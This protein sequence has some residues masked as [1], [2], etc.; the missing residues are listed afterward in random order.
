MRIENTNQPKKTTSTKKNKQATGS[1]FDGL[2]GQV[3][4]TNNAAA[5]SGASEVSAIDGLLSIQE[6]TGEYDT[7]GEQAKHRGV[8]LLDHLEDIRN[9][10]LLG[11]IS[12]SRLQSLETLVE[13]TRTTTDDPKLEAILNDIEIR[14]AVELAKWNN[15][16]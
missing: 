4:E 12:A 6:V 7:L 13:Q 15:S 14:A 3:K 5:A 10:I 8:A 9:G 2:L 11:H 16:I 1:N